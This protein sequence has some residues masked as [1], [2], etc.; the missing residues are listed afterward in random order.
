MLFSDTVPGCS[1][2]LCLKTTEN[3]ATA[4]CLKGWSWHVLSHVCFLG[5]PFRMYLFLGWDFGTWE[6]T[7]CRFCS[8]Q[9][10]I[11]AVGCNSG[12]VWEDKY[13][14]IRNTL[15]KLATNNRNHVQENVNSIHVD[16]ALRR[17]VLTNE[18]FHCDDVRKRTRHYLGVQWG[19]FL[20]WIHFTI[21]IGAPHA[22]WSDRGSHGS[23]HFSTW[24]LHQ[25]VFA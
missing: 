15:I 6:N 21:V 24:V 17:F 19:L 23:I 7:S 20:Y 9:E 10:T 2:M 4:G 8:S 3:I 1:N 5:L 16:G 18:L 25:E 11:F 14:M 12:A 22:N 13:S